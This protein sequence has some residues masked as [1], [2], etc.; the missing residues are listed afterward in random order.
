MKNKRLG[1]LAVGLLMA[2]A[3]HGG[4]ITFSTDSATEL[5]GTFSFSGTLDNLTGVAPAEFALAGGLSF[6]GTLQGGRQYDAFSTDAA[7]GFVCATGPD[8][9]SSGSVDIGP[10]LTT[11][12]DRSGFYNVA[13]GTNLS[14]SVF[15]RYFDWQDTGGPDGSFTGAFCFS[16]SATACSA[17]SVPEPGTLALLSLGLLG[18]GLLRRQ[19]AD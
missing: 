12:A 2:F 3:A 5:R 6:C 13:A 18:L 19:R 16:T 17:T 14:E 9:A 4:T 8:D 15:F 7:F 11:I 1:L 10:G